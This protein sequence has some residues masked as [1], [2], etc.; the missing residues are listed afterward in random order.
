MTMTKS[1]DPHCRG[2]SAARLPRRPT[3]FAQ[4]MF[5]GVLS[6][7]LLTA[8]SFGQDEK[9][10]S[11][12]VY[13]LSPF[14][15]EASDEKGY[16]ATSTLAGSRLKTPLRDVGASI[17]VITE[18]FLED[19][20]ADGPGDLLI[21]TAG[22]EI[23]G[24]GG[25]FAGGSLIRD[26]RPSQDA[27]RETPESNQRVRG[28]AQAELTRDYFLTDVPFDSYNVERIAISRGPNSLLFGIGSPGGVVN[29]TT[30][31]PLLSKDTAEISVRY[32]QHGSW[33][34]TLDVNRALVEDRVA[35]RIAAL[36][37]DVTYRQEPAFEEDRRLF[38]A[39][40]AV[41]RQPQGDS[42]FGPTTFRANAER[43]DIESNPPNVT[44][45][46]DFFSG[47]W[48][49]PFDV[50][51]V[52]PF[53]DSLSED[54]WTDG[55]FH[56]KGTVNNLVNGYP[57]SVP[58][59]KTGGERQQ[60]LFP[61]FTFH[62]AD[63]TGGPSLGF[64]DPE[65]NAL[66]GG[67][68]LVN[69]NQTDAD[70]PI[71]RRFISAN[72]YRK[73]QGFAVPTIQ[74]RKVF[75]Y[76]NLLMSGTTNHAERDFE[77]EN[78]TIEQ[79]LWRGNAG[80]EVSFDK[81]SQDRF[82]FFP[83][84]G[85]FGAGAGFADLAVDISEF[86]TNDEPNPNLGRI[87]VRSMFLEDK[88]VEIDRDALRATAFVTLDGA[89]LFGGDRAKFWFGRHTLTGLYFDQEIDTREER[90]RFGI[91]SNEVDPGFAFGDPKIGNWRRRMPVVAYLGDPLFDV[92]SPGDVR[93]TETINVDLP[94]DGEEHLGYYLDRDAGEI[95]TAKFFAR[96]FLSGGDIGRREIESSAAS[97]QSY[98]LDQHLITLFG[99]REDE[100]A[101]FSRVDFDGDDDPNTSEELPGGEFN[102]DAIALNP[103]PIDVSKGDTV[104][105]S[106]MAVYPEKWLGDLPLGADLRIFYNTSENFNPVGARRNV[107]NEILDPP[108]GETDEYGLIISLF[109]GKVSGRL[110]VFE[111]TAANTTDPNVSAETR[112]SN[113]QV[114][115]WLR[116]WIDVENDGIPLEDTGATEKGFSSYEEVYNEI[117]SFMPESNRAATR[118]GFTGAPGSRELVYNSIENVAATTSFA[119]KGWEFELTGNPTKSIRFLMNIAKQETVLTD[120]VP[121]L[122]RLS[123]SVLAA[124]EAS[125]LSDLFPDNPSAI[126]EK[127]TFRSRYNGVVRR[128][129]VNEQQKDGTISLEQREWRANAVI[130]YAFQEG[131]LD[132]FEIGSGW[133][134]QS[135]AAVGYPN[136]VDPELGRINDLS[137]PYK[138]DD[139]LNGDLWARYTRDLFGE[140]V[141]WQIQLNVRN[142]IGSDDAIPLT[143][144]PDGS[145]GVIRVGPQTRWSITNTFRF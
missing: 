27:A 51:S 70:R 110:N 99:V 78:Y 116:Q 50:E 81:Q 47:W 45:P 63:A 140:S 95:K 87:A 40:T 10:S 112:R 48:G 138:T 91:D 1:L 108:S 65:L 120:I 102:P 46:T 104:T 114:S 106:I 72:P 15:I 49:V 28:L 125:P 121:E 76:V 80:I 101:V 133:R 119:A 129:V 115:T 107:F 26:G 55:T 7:I 67:I 75:D 77:T 132:G 126:D 139:E 74:D 122:D 96:R 88:R 93:I 103:V 68:A 44:P 94:K 58:E 39:I 105:A 118:L 33:R 62:Y 18:Q 136:F 3:A 79:S 29:N 35:V 85:S 60:F 11:D 69:W 52:R 19:I 117:M 20:A 83:F 13:E 59:G 100:Q 38:G 143:I 5:A 36:N 127:T 145:V 37:D 71:A 137:R 86:M 123:A 92:A 30:I 134:Y 16:S 64:A 22:T 56:A 66:A 23:G 42:F 89:D 53:V 57:W 90:H 98:L 124:V 32:G 41:L 141:E 73:L 17:S 14:V 8:A 54:Y 130:A 43:I 12:G 2:H 4:R 34:Q 84:G 113:D 31:K 109:E 111:T 131:L 135:G 24:M 21:Y 97:L 82:V 142:A 61:Q 25:N 9:D 128:G 144:N 6:T